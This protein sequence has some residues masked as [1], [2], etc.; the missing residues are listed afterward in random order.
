MRFRSNRFWGRVSMIP[1]TGLAIVRNH[2]NPG[3]RLNSASPKL[4]LS[5]VEPYAYLFIS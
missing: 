3:L 5:N 1:R 2:L 4:F